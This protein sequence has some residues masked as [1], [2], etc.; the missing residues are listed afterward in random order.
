MTNLDKQDMINTLNEQ[1]G[2]IIEINKCMGTVTIPGL[3]VLIK[4][5]T[6]DILECNKLMM[7]IIDPPSYKLV[8][9]FDKDET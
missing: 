6:K 9:L 5:F 2:Y 3:L 7:E 4:R 1:M 8:K